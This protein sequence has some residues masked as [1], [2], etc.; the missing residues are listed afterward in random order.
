MAL[1]AGAAAG[2]L[3]SLVFHVDR[4]DTWVPATGDISA[5][6]YIVGYNIDIA[7]ARTLGLVTLTF[8]GGDITAA[9]AAPPTFQATQQIENGTVVTAQ[10]TAHGG[11]LRTASFV[12]RG[13]DLLITEV[14][15]D[16]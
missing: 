1:S 12:A 7:G 6:G 8:P 10:P 14:W 3:S 15:W 13:S 5:C 11:T 16:V 2:N 4:N 9:A